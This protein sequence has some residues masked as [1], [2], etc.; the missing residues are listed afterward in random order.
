MGNTFAAKGFAALSIRH[1]KAVLRLIF[2]A[3]MQILPQRVTRMVRWWKG[4]SSTVNR[5][6]AS[7]TSIEL[8]RDQYARSAS[9]IGAERGRRSCDCCAHGPCSGQCRNPSNTACVGGLARWLVPA[10]Q[11][12]SYL[13]AGSLRRPRL[14]GLSAAGGTQ[15]LPVFSS[16]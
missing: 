16:I 15:G 6:M 10:W 1:A 9:G 4:Y 14:V 11:M 8:C 13:V 3:P 12:L 5:C 2:I 7:G